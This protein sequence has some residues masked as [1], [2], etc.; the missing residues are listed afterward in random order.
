MIYNFVPYVTLTYMHHINF[1]PKPEEFH[2]V[3]ELLDSSH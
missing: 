2:E 1:K 3:T